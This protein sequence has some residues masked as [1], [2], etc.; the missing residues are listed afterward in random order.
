[1]NIENRRFT[2]SLFDRLQDD[3][4]SVDEITNFSDSSHSSLASMRANLK[5]DIENLLNTRLRTES[6][7]DRLTAVKGSI[8]NY[9][10]PDLTTLNLQ[11]PVKCQQFCQR[12]EQTLLQYEPRLYSVK[13]SFIEAPS[14]RKPSAKGESL[15]QLHFRIDAVM[16]ADPAPEVVIFFSHFDPVRLGIDLQEVTTL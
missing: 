14:E 4:P 13:V 6:T 12:L 8:L 7:P 5:R 3:Q 1:M 2:P 10:L 16:Y 15:F 9:G 11:N